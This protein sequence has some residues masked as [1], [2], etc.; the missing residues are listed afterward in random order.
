MRILILILFPLFSFGQL[1]QTQWSIGCGFNT[2]YPICTN[3]TCGRVN[4]NHQAV[5][6]AQLINYWGFPNKGWGEEEYTSNY[7]FLYTDYTIE[8]D[9]TNISRL[10][11]DCDIAVNSNYSI[12]MQAWQCGII[13]LDTINKALHDHFGYKWGNVITNNLSSLISQEI[14]QGRPVI[15]ELYPTNFQCSRFVVVDGFDGTNFHFNF[16]VNQIGGWYTLDN[17]WAMGVYWT[18]EQKALI[19]IEPDEMTISVSIVND[20]TSLPMQGDFFVNGLSQTTMQKGWYNVTATSNEQ[21]AGPNASDA[22]AALRMFVGYYY[23]PFSVLCAEVSGDG[24]V[25]ALDAMLIAKRFVGQINSFPVSDWKHM[26][27]TV[28]SD[29]NIVIRMRCSGDTN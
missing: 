20:I 16:G 5:A 7:G 9:W 26:P 27:I 28:C 3:G 11:L 14:A 22:L 23:S 10:M 24:I 25:N 6:M 8:R 19:G 21:W 18:L 17:V 15:M 29:T 13:T 12:Y 2:E 4:V 1:L